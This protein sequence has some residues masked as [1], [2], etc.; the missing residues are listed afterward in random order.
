MMGQDA[1]QTT[2]HLFSRFAD[3]ASGSPMYRYLSQS[4]SREPDL[5]VLAA[6]ADR[7]QPVPNL[8][9]A[10]IHFLLMGHSEERLARYY[11]S[12]GGA[13]VPSSEMFSCFKDFCVRFAPEITEIL[14]TRLVQTN[15]VQR[16][17]V[18]VPALSVICEA[19]GRRD[20]TLVDVGASGGLNL[21]MDKAH[22]EYSDGSTAGP[23]DSDL[24][25]KCDSR[26]AQIPTLVPVSISTR[27]GVDLNPVDLLNESVRQWSLSLIWPD[28]VERF[29]RLIKA[30]SVL[31][32][33]DLEFHRGDAIQVLPGVLA[34]LSKDQLLCIMHSFTL[35]Q[36]SRSDRQA[37]DDVLAAASSHRDVWR[38]ALEWIDTE[39][40]ELS[41]YR[42]VSGKLESTRKLAECHGHG[43]WI[44]WIPEG[45]S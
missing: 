8:F 14:K 11:P 27:I 40:P 39:N 5:L 32:K 20:V 7:G 33:T 45:A 18:L 35:N 2:A 1:G 3:Q 13:F 10:A 31:Q 19:A 44:A 21:T 23:E 4:V 28:Q 42:Y 36:F 34:N 26:G 17:A 6:Y 29:Q 22:I 37:F 25:L 15:E 16:C 43:E 9:F 41:I 38:I 12:L 30:L 24:R